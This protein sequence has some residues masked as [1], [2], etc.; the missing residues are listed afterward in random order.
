MRKHL[1]S[2]ERQCLG[3]AA[4]DGAQEDDRSGEDHGGPEATP[5]CGPAHGEH[6]DREHYG[7]P[8]AHHGNRG[9]PP[10][11]EGCIHTLADRSPR[12]PQHT[13]WTVC[14]FR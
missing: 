4:D 12:L 6:E 5:D 10:A 13:L 8:V 1:H 7:A 3:D 2:E 11:R 14:T 9:R